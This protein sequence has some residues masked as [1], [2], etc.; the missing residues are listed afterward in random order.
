[1]NVVIDPDA[2]DA[3]DAV[4][5]A[6][7]IVA[8]TNVRNLTA[9]PLRPGSVLEYTVNIQISDYFTFT[10]LLATHVLSDGQR[11]DL[12]FT[13]TLEVTGLLPAGG[14]TAST[15]RSSLGP[16]AFA[17]PGTVEYQRRFTGSSPILNGPF[18]ETFDAARDGSTALT[19][20]LSDE[21]A[22]RGFNRRLQGGAVP[23]LGFGSVSAPGQLPSPN[24]PATGRLV[25]RAIVRE[26]YSDAFPSGDPSF[27]LGDELVGAI[28]TELDGVRGVILEPTGGFPVVGVDGDG[29]STG[30]TAP[31][32]DLSTGVYAINGVVA[33][34]PNAGYP[35]TVRL[36]PGDAVTLRL[37][38]ALPFSA[39]E[40]LRLT[41]VL[42]NNV[43][44]ILD[45][46]GDPADT[47]GPSWSFNPVVG[48]P[49]AGVVQFGPADT[50]YAHTGSALVPTL[51]VDGGANSIR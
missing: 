1:V 2:S 6:K 28:P 20:R 15:P 11:L 42:P 7:S 35:G 4:V 16:N 29:S 19:F 23:N 38:Y 14:I 45:P 8:K 5:V 13:P 48:I 27:D 39:F 21:L 32:G 47:P 26:D 25:F 22:A 51:S 9:G 30:I 12:G 17:A 31:V 41:G 50:F 10:D 40:Q 24:G 3:D 36:N 49:A 37:R 18:V 46:D 33:P 43:F 34:D 44:S